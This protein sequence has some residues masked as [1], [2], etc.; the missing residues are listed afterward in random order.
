M[1]RVGLHDELLSGLHAA[2]P[3]PYED[4]V[5]LAHGRA[6]AVTRCGGPGLL[7]R[8]DAGRS[9]LEPALP[10]ARRLGQPLPQVPGEGQTRDREHEERRPPPQRGRDQ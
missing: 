3:H 2:P 5:V 8:D 4:G 6:V 1:V 9:G 7:G 10:A